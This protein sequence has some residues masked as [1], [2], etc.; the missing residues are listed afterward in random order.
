[1]AYASVDYLEGLRDVIRRET[2]EFARRAWEFLT[3]LE[4]CQYYIDD[5]GL[6]IRIGVTSKRAPQ[7]FDLFQRAIF[8]NNF[9]AHESF[10]ANGVYWTRFGY[11]PSSPPRCVLRRRT[12]HAAH[13]KTGFGVVR[14]QT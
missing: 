14:T 6:G 2:E 8:R 3:P 7:L 9:V 12:R 1:M 10:V 13:V 5:N 4:A 11:Y